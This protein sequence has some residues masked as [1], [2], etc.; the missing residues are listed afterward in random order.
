M[1]NR[2]ESGSLDDAARYFRASPARRFNS[3][4]GTI[5]PKDRGLV[6]LDRDGERVIDQMTWGF[7]LVL[8]GKKGQPLKPKPVNN[9]RFDKLDGFW[10]RWTAPANRCLIPV[11]RYAEAEGPKGKKT[12]T[13]LSVADRPMM[14]WA[15]LWRTNDD[16][17][18][19]DCY[20]GVMTDAAPELAKIHDRA[21][22]ILAADD[23]ETW[24]TAPLDD[25]Y[26]FDRPWPAA[27]VKVDAT[28]RS[29]VR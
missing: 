26:K 29:W 24:L 18:W 11:T 8:K 17:E 23:W 9:A 4:G 13:W 16:E 14:A 1:C 2:Y 25:L 19:G 5:H 20:T 22:V 3:G 27:A 28:D 10:K 12:E 21:P 6:V 15:G 7:P